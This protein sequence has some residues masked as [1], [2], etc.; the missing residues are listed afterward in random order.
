MPLKLKCYQQKNTGW[1]NEDIMRKEKDVTRKK[2]KKPNEIKL[3]NNPWKS[4]F[5]ILIA[6]L[7]G[8]GLFLYGRISSPRMTYSQSAPKTETRSKPIFQMVMKKDQVNEILNF[9]LDE[10]MKESGMDYSLTLDNETLLDGTFSLFDH[11]THFY[12]YFE[13]FVLSD[14]N[15]QLKAKS[16]SVGTLNVPIPAM[17][18]YISHS[19]DF[20]EWVEI[21]PDKQLITLHLDQFKLQNGM[22]VKATTI[23]LIDDEIKFSLYLPKEKNK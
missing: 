12:L 5:L 23:N 8:S 4:A 19:M 15:I 22:T 2:M 9:Y 11:E 10:Y 20:P 21:D 3:L 7:I 14:G 6:M 18:N 1:S 13:P 17:I 16:L